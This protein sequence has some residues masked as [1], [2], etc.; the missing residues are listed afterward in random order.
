MQ[1]LLTSRKRTSTQF[2]F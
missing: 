1:A 2:R